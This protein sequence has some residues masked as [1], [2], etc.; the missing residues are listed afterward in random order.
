M[1][2]LAAKRATQPTLRFTQIVI[3]IAGCQATNTNVMP[4]PEN[5]MSLSVIHAHPNA[6]AMAAISRS[7][8][9]L[10]RAQLGPPQVADDARQSADSALDLRALWQ[11]TQ[12]NSPSLREAEADV[13]TARGQQ[14]QAGKYPNPKLAYTEDLIGSRAIRGG[15]ESVQITQEIVTGGKRRLDMAIAGRETAAADLGLMSRK[16]EVMTRLRRAY[17]AYLG[18]LAIVD[19]NEAAVASLH[20]GV[21]TTRRQVAATGRRTDL[22]RLESLLE[23]TKIS[24]ARS[25][26]NLEAA[27]KQV[28]AEVGVADL[29]MPRSV[30]GFPTPGPD[31]SGDT[32]RERVLA[33]NSALQQA[34]AEVERSRLA[35]D[36]A[37]AEAIP[38]ITVGAGYANAPIESTA[39]AIVTVEAPLPVWDRKQ[40]QIRAAQA[41]WLKAQAAA[42]R[43]EV[44]LAA[45]GAETWA[46]YQS[47][48]L[49]VDKLSREVLPRLEE[50]VELLVKGYESGGA[51]VTF[52]DVLTTQQTLIETRLK[53]A[54]AKQALWQA[55]ADLQGLMQLD[56]NEN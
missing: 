20:K 10:T 50:S 52:T 26:F 25:Q 43:V 54:D 53:R 6:V 44:A 56:I 15:N 29:P 3:L 4:P 12:A 5:A 8:V 40:G 22:L 7:S 11:M 47:A 24:L 34:Q 41:R 21:A 45:A 2:D 19:L 48:R 13:E 32:V 51:G 16:F 28:T 33:G 37:R 17:Y 18:A 1:A 38:N 27:W 9:T 39:G 36:R 55:A 35:V 30:A 23:Q 31:W 46:R 49:E 14:I 42:R